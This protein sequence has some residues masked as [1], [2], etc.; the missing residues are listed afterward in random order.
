[1]KKLIY[2]FALIAGTL[3]ILVTL[4]SLIYDVR[5]WFLKVLDFPRM[6]TLIGLLICLALYPFVKHNW[7]YPSI[8]FV[9]GLVISVIIQLTYIVP[10]TFLTP[11]AVA[12]AEQGMTDESSFKLLVANVWMKNDKAQAFL[13]VVNEADPDIIIVMETNTWW[14]DQLSSLQSRYPHQVLRPL[15]NT[16][17]MLLFSKFPLENTRVMHLKHKD[18]PSIHSK[19]VLPNGR[20]FMLRA[21]HPVPPKPSEHPD[22]VGEKELELIKIGQMVTEREIPVIVAGDFNDVAW[23]RTSRLFGTESKLNDIRVGRGFYNSFDAKSFIMRWPLDHIFVSEDFRVVDLQ[24]LPKFGSDHFP[25]MAE[26]T[27]TTPK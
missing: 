3:L 7:K 9:S 19:V 8:L 1:M 18:V 6:Q 12:S 4:L 23:S 17:G 25:I 11:N 24:K 15:D 2:Y 20:E 5:F 10:Y 27:L 21:V 16:Y 13:D 22:N 26:L 14:K